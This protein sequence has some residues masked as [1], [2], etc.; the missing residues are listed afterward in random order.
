VKSA[1]MKVWAVYFDDS[2]MNDFVLD[3]LVQIP[4]CINE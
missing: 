3:I 1:F 2:A 4:S